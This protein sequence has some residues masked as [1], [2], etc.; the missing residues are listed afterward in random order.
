MHHMGALG[1]H[2]R[3]MSLYFECKCTGWE[4]YALDGSRMVPLGVFR[5]MG[6][7]F[8]H[9]RAMCNHMGPVM[10][11]GSHML[12]FPPSGAGWEPWGWGGS[13]EALCTF[14]S[15]AALLW[16]RNAGVGLAAGSYLTRV[17]VPL[18]LL[19]R[20]RSWELP[21]G[22]LSFSRRCPSSPGSH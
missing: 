20:S 10:P 2:G 1:C 22:T 17:K 5:S 16:Q 14:G 12:P 11:Y 8:P 21:F 7:V 19:H 6:A 15:I 4:H 9:V 18:P 13:Q 3:C